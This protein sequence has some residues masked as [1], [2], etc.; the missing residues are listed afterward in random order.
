MLVVS[1]FFGISPN[2]SLSKKQGW[3]TH[4]CGN[5]IEQLLPQQASRIVYNER[6]VFAQVIV[7]YVFQFDGQIHEQPN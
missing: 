1:R 7:A 2:I 6:S 3:L 4:V 5:D